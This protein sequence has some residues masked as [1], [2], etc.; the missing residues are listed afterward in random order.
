MVVAVAA[1]VVVLGV[2]AVRQG[3]PEAQP[4]AIAGV[5]A[6]QAQSAECRALLDA[7]PE[8]LGDYRRAATVDPTPAGAA[9]WQADPG[10]EP[11]I[12]RCG[13]DRPADFTVASPLQVV[14]PVQWFRVGEAGAGDDRVGEAGAGDDRVGEAGAG[15]D[16]VGEAGAGDASARSTWYVVD[17]PV[18]VALTLPAGSGP[19]P[20]QKISEAVAETMPAT[21]PDPAPIS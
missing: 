21:R 3:S 10:G 7:L 14:A 19:T 20:I 16:R 13:L 8:Q 9:A 6:P 5:P 12:L 15:D 11:V 2:A 4:V 1:V 18:Y 17:R